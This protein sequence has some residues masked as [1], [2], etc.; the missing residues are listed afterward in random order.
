MVIC[1]NFVRQFGWVNFYSF[2]SVHFYIVIDKFG[3]PIN[4]GWE[5]L[6]WTTVMCLDMCAIK[7]ETNIQVSLF[8]RGR[9]VPLFM[10]AE[11][12]DKKTF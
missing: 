3:G 2:L 10:T 8:I 7:R 6:S 9:Y 12:A 4:R 1:R 5:T 11:F